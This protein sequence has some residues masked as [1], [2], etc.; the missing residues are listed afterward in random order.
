[1][2]MKY[3]GNFHYRISGSHIGSYEEFCVAA[4]FMIFSCLAYSSTL[5][6]EA[7]GCSEALVD[8]QQ[9]TDYNKL[10]T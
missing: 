1:M 7:T 6:M 2:K 10:C 8:F 4:C 5:K 3:C 9:L